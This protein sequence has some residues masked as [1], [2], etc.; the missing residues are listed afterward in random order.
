MRVFVDGCFDLPHY[1]HANALRQARALGTSLTVGVIAD[2]N[3]ALYKV[4]PV[5]TLEER[6]E[7][8]AAMRGVDVLVAGVPHTLDERFTRWLRKKHGVGLIVHGD[9]D[10]TMPDGSDPYKTARDL[11]MYWVVPRTPGISTTDIV[12]AL[13]EDSSVPPTPLN[14]NIPEWEPK[15]DTCYVDGAFD[16]LHN[17]HVA[18]L[19]EA[20]KLAKYLVV[21]LHDSEDVVHRRG[22]AP[23][24]SLVDRARALT[25]CKYV[26]GVILGPPTTVTPHFL[27][28]IQAKCVARG[29]VHETRQPDGDRYKGVSSVLIYIPSPSSMTLDTIRQRVLQNREVYSRKVAAVL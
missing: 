28:A 23:V 10:T 7:L 27:Q 3:I 29:A 19:R 20:S 18:F 12:R 14:S 22:Q 6:C 11:G 15:P 9:D 26:S 13:L 4:P 25:A 2:E 24:L 16:V 5:L 1:G 17:G 21:G 8:V